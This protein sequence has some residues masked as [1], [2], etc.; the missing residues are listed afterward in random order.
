MIQIWKDRT[1]WGDCL[2]S[3]KLHRCRER[4]D[5]SSCVNFNPE[6]KVQ[7]HAFCDTSEK[8]YAVEEIFAHL[9]AAKTVKVQILPCLEFCCATLV[10]KDG[11]TVKGLVNPGLSRPRSEWQKFHTQLETFGSN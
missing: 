1:E 3:M 10:A 4:I 6:W 11:M 7:H 5:I 9:L 8:A 2:K